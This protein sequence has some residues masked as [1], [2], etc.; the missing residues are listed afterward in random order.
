MKIKLLTRFKSSLI[1]VMIFSLFFSVSSWA[2]QA[3]NIDS[4][5]DSNRKEGIEQNIGADK[6]PKRQFEIPAYARVFSTE[7]SFAD[8]K[9]DLLE[10]VANHGLVVSYTSHAKTML[11]NTAAVSSVLSAV[12][13]NAEILLFCKADLSH[14]LVAANPHNIVL[15]PYSIAIYVLSDEPE[16]VYLSYRSVEASD[17]KIKALTKPIEDLLIEIIEEII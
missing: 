8:A 16:R 17:E 2:D 7:S 9:D 10:A 1:S 11:D 6:K 12:Y 13:A 14:K 15:C 3:V 5:D 4:I